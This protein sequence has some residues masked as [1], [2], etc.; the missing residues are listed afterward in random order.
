MSKPV[1][2][3]AVAVAM[4]AGV[5]AQAAAAGGIPLAADLQGPGARELGH[6]GAR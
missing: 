2:V 5:G 6:E 3:L 4:A 1:G